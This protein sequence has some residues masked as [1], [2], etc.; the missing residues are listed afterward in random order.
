MCT[1]HKMQTLAIEWSW[2][3]N[4]KKIPFVKSV[5]KTTEAKG[6]ITD[7]TLCEYK[8]LGETNLIHPS[9]EIFT[10]Y[11][12]VKEDTTQLFFTRV[13]EHGGGGSYHHLAYFYVSET[14]EEAQN[15][16]FE[17]FDEEHHFDGCGDCEEEDGKCVNEENCP[18]REKMEEELVKD[19][20]VSFIGG[21]EEGYSAQI[22]AFTLI[23]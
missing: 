23:N 11:I 19:G 12:T 20:S 5:K 14:K 13:D 21:S 4:E 6:K 17:W 15:I 7:L 3:H 9:E 18:C 16:V 1:A 10:S 8:L 2:A 22:A